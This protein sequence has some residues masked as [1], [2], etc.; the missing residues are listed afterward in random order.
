MVGCANNNSSAGAAKNNKSSNNYAIE[1]NVEVSENT[2][3]N[4][5]TSFPTINEYISSLKNIVDEKIIGEG[6][7]TGGKYEF[8]FSTSISTTKVKLFLN[9]NN[10]VVNAFF[11][12]NGSQ[13]NFLNDLINT[14]AIGVVLMQPLCEYCETEYF[15]NDT[16]IKSINEKVQEELER[17]NY[18]LDFSVDYQFGDCNFYISSI[19]LAG[20]LAGSIV[21]TVVTGYKVETDTSSVVEN[22]A[23]NGD[24]SSSANESQSQDNSSFYSIQIGAFSQ[25]DNADRML[26]NAQSKGFDAYIMKIDN[27]YKIRIGRF[28]SR[29]DAETELKSIISAGYENAFIVK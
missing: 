26:S 11:M 25:K 23:Q 1:D 28:N 21:F 29:A 4:S 10:E 7:I 24:I 22:D 18:Q 8:D 3:S 19:N 12:A 17:N 9:E 13:S 16:V 20:N 2:D 5:K 6:I 27:L 14:M 15:D